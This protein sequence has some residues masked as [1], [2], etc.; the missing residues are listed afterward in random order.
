MCAARAA[1]EEAGYSFRNK[2]IHAEKLVPLVS[3][4]DREEGEGSWERK[5]ADK[6]PS[7][8]LTQQP[9]ALW[10]QEDPAFKG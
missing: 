9:P 3:S 4:G 6:V 8:A 2:T 7:L 5:R 10:T 1:W